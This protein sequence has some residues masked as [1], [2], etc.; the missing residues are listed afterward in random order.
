MS[1]L[2][3]RLADSE[4]KGQEQIANLQEQVNE[5]RETIQNLTPY[6]AEDTR[7]PSR[8]SQ[9]TLTVRLLCHREPPNHSEDHSASMP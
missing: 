9:P 1:V 7:D 6:K 4:H 8:H 3:D 2:H 5:R